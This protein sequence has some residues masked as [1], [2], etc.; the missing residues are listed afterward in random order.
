VAAAAANVTFD[1]VEPEVPTG[2]DLE[3]AR[4][5]R[6]RNRTTVSLRYA[7]ATHEVTVAT[8]DPPLDSDAD[9]ET[10]SLGTVNVTTSSFTDITALRWQCDGLGYTVTGNLSS[11]EIR[12]VA[13]DAAT[14]CSRSH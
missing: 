5:S 7:N 9:G 1:V 2:F 11:A 6:F 8:R 4:V 13:R 14:A 10:V 12:D 3:T